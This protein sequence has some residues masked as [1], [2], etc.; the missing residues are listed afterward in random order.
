MTLPPS[1]ATLS[2]VA[3][4]IPEPPPVTSMTLPSKVPAMTFSFQPSAGNY[5]TGPQ[6]SLQL[7]RSRRSAGNCPAATRLRWSGRQISKLSEYRHVIPRHPFLCELAV[8]HAQ[9]CREI[10][11]HPFAR[12]RKCPHLAQLRTFVCCPRGHHMPLRNHVREGLSVIRKHRRVLPEK[13]FELLQAA[14]LQIR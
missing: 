4:P 14:N 6:L 5:T 11:S 3:R 1:C 9:D 10:E 7:I 12:R 13:I 2:A 8:R